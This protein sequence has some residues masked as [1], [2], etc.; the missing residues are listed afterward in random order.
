MLLKNKQTNKQKKKNKQTKANI[1]FYRN[2]SGIFEAIPLH[3]AYC[4]LQWE[5]R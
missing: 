4:W 1:L 2:H 3:E 5:Q